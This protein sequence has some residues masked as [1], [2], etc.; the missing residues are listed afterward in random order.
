VNKRDLRLADGFKL[1]GVG[2]TVLPS[3]QFESVSCVLIRVVG[4]CR[5][6]AK[7]YMV[8]VDAVI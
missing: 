4:R 3:E 8:V 6:F 7:A 1:G 5:L 2:F